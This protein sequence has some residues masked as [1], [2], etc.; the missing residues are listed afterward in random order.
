MAMTLSDDEYTVLMLANDG[1]SMIPIGRWKKPILDLTDKGYMKEHDSVN[2][3][4]TSKGRQALHAHEEKVDLGL[5]EACDKVAKSKNQANF[6]ADEAVKCLVEAARACQPHSDEGYDFQLADFRELFEDAARRLRMM[7]A[8][9]TALEHRL[10][11]TEH[12]RADGPFPT[13]WR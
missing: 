12:D 2:Y 10:K 5:I 1:N 13:T 4:I 9:C 6:Y 8:Q 7:H 3:G 11:R